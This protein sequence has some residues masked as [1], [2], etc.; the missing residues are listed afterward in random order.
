MSTDDGEPSQSPDPVASVTQPDNLWQRWLP[1]DGPFYHS[2]AVLGFD[3]TSDAELDPRPGTD[4]PELQFCTGLLRLALRNTPGLVLVGVALTLVIEQLNDF[5]LPLGTYLPLEAVLPTL[6]PTHILGLTVIVVW[7]AVLVWIV[8]SSISVDNSGLHRT[9]LFYATASTL[10]AGVAYAIFLVQ[11]NRVAGTQQHITFR[12]GYFLFILLEGYLAYDGLALRGEN[13]FW[14]LERSKIVDR[15]QYEQFRADL[16]TNLGPV[17]VPFTDEETTVVPSEVSPGLLFASV[18]ILP[19]IPLPLLTYQ[20]SH[21]VLGMLGYGIT[22]VFQVFL[23]GVLFQFVVLLWQFGSLLSGDYLDYKPFHPDEHGGYRALGQFA[24]RV[25][26]MLFVAGG[27][28]AFRFVT[29]GITQYRAIAG[30]SIV[31]LSTWVVS[32][33]AP[34]L[35]YLVVVVLWLYVSFW[36]MHCQMRRGRRE[37]IQKLQQRARNDAPD[38]EELAEEELEDLNL[39]APAWESLRSAPV[40]PVKHRNLVVI[41]VMDTIPILISYF[42]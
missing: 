35:V 4:K 19:L 8:R 20:T 15:Q 24:T 39:D 38:G 11:T 40:W 42:I 33:V 22:I 16:A 37:K 36:R 3:A 7:A 28:V 18:L 41:G 14:N 34:I 29:G 2:C 26:V 30:D 6:G 17:A 21:P 27:Y 23:I 32:F 10:F 31:G 25:N 12:A 5:Y 1:I 9:I 13:L